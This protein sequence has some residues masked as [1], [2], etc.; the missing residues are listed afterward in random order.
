MRSESL[1]L[2]KNFQKIFLIPFGMYYFQ[3]HLFQ[4]GNMLKLLSKIC[5]VFSLECERHYENINDCIAISCTSPNLV[6]V[7]NHKEQIVLN[8]VIQSSLVN[9][10]SCLE[11]NT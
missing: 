10:K 9:A 6:H 8:Y 1:D 4:I 5:S 11:I 3:C 7:K 2:I